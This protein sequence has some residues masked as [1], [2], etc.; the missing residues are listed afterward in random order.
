ML[1]IG[2]VGQ[3][4]EVALSQILNKNSIYRT[5]L[6]AAKCLQESRFRMILPSRIWDMFLLTGNVSGENA[7]SVFRTDL[8]YTEVGDHSFLR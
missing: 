2:G 1:I 4:S 5:V 8:L 3:M 6:L 7:A